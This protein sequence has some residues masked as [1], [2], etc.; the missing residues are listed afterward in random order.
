MIKKYKAIFGKIEECEILR[1]T[2]K[3]IVKVNSL[4]REVRE[5]K[6]SDWQSYHDTYEDAKA[7]L[8]QKEEKEVDRLKVL[9]KKAVEQ[10]DKMKAL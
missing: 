3:Q 2:D 8:I 6:I 7:H 9:L 10:L 4:G 5:S 1:E